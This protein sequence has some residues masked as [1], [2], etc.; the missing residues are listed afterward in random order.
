MQVPDTTFHLAYCSNIHAGERW[1]EVDAA[2]RWALPAIRSSLGHRG[3]MAVGLRLS[4]EAAAT[5]EKAQNLPRFRR[6]LQDGDYYVPTINGFP[7]GSFHGTRVKER[8][9]E[10]DWRTPARVEYSNRLARIVAAL[11]L[12]PAPSRL[13]VST[14]PG[15][16]RSAITAAEDV[17]AIARNLLTH[18]AYLKMLRKDTGRLVTLAMEPE[19]A[20]FIETSVEAVTFF[21]DYLYASDRVREAGDRCG[22]EMTRQ[23]VADHVGLCLD[24]CHMAVQFENPA[25]VIHEVSEAG[26]TIAKVQLSSALRVP[27]ESAHAAARLLGAFAEDTYLHQVVISTEEGLIRYVDLPG[28][29]ADSQMGSVP[30]GEWRVHF[31]VPIFVEYLDGF[32]T[33]QAL[34]KQTL[35]ALREHSLCPCLEVETYT[36]DVLPP[37]YRT[38]DV[39]TAIASELAW[40]RNELPR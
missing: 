19:P 27:A 17:D 40:V 8:V 32:E 15:G 28:A 10:P 37:E 38:S 4:A 35:Q 23:D 12:A 2:L 22:I 11:A 39:C 13:S 29:L 25:Q 5:L 3:P 20:C 31:H 18:A 1:E 36:W 14:V 7:Y 24:T 16:F 30:P 34:V 9:Y 6:F 21:R 26:I 33:T